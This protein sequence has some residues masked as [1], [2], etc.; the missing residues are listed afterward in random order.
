MRRSCCI[1]A[2]AALSVV[3]V[4]IWFRDDIADELIEGEYDPWYV[5]AGRYEGAWRYRGAPDELAVFAQGLDRV[6][7][8]IEEPVSGT[9]R[10]KGPMDGS[11]A[12]GRGTCVIG[13]REYPFRLLRENPHEHVLSTND[14]WVQFESEAP[15][16]FLTNRSWGDGFELM[17]EAK[18]DPAGDW[19]Y[20]WFGLN[21]DLTSM[22]GF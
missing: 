6:E 10:G 5:Q 19:L 9:W 3:S 15:L 8:R 21:A 16:P 18:R 4:L 11:T 1:L 13:G 17:L 12:P 20:L 14:G 22:D 2:L 7:F